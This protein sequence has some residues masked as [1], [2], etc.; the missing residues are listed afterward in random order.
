MW[1]ECVTILKKKNCRRKSQKTLIGIEYH[2]VCV[3]EGDAVRKMVFLLIPTAA[4]WTALMKR[5]EVKAKPTGRLLG[6]G[7][8]GRV[9]EPSS[10]GKILAGKVFKIK[11]IDRQRTLLFGELS[12]MPQ[13]HHPNVVQYKEV[14]FLENET[15]SN[16]TTDEQSLCLP[17]YTR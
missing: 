10:A 2:S 5:Y 3:L 17:S 9:I 8:Y 1:S 16:E 11:T 7:K 15:V 12:F 14:C 13:V 4:H 6:R